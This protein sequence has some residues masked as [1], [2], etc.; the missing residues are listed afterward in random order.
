MNLISGRK[1]GRGGPTVWGQ[2]SPGLKKTQG[3]S[4]NLLAC[5]KACNVTTPPLPLTCKLLTSG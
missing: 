2:L 4:S 1:Q 3:T 5:R